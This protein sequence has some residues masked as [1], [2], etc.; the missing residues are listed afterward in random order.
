[1][2]LT[3]LKC[4][5]AKPVAKPY[6]I[7]DGQGLHLLIAPNGSKYWRMRYSYGGKNKCLALGVYPEVAL[8]EA[9][10]KTFEARRQL[11]EGNNPIQL[12]REKKLCAVEKTQNTFEIAARA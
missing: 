1:M 7:S 11:R 5:H 10:E 2:K 3:D 12:K 6:K 4:R 9:R 8:L